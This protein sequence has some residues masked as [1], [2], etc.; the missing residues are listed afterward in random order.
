MYLEYDDGNFYIWKIINLKIFERWADARAPEKW[1]R[2]RYDF[3]PWVT[4]G[5]GG[6][7]DELCAQSY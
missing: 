5:L 3:K 6:L 1:S 7:W 4:S 2:P